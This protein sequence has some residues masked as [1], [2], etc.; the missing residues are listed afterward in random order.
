M[1]LH[2]VIYRYAEEPDR[3][4]EHRPRHKDYLARCTNK[5]GS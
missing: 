1:S 3:L 4:D 2:A 5:A